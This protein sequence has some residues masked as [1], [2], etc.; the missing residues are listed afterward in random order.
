MLIYKNLQFSFIHK[1]DYYR[2]QLRIT[3]PPTPTI[4]G[5]S[6]ATSPIYFI[7]KS[8]LY[9]GKYRGSPDHSPKHQQ[10]KI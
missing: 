2:C 8:N 3:L 10:K 9:R 6:C 1:F 7:A 4:T 5:A